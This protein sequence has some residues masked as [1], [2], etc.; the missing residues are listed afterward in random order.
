[1]NPTTNLVRTC[2]INNSKYANLLDLTTLC[3]DDSLE[4]TYGKVQEAINNCHNR[5][6]LERL[7]HEA[8][9]LEKTNPGWDFKGL[10]PIK[11][12]ISVCI[13]QTR[14]RLFTYLLLVLYGMISTWSLDPIN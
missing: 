3:C 14:V 6:K 10:L 2:Q 1:M 8:R 11:P 9:D 12:K 13:I 5:Q 4:L 7:K